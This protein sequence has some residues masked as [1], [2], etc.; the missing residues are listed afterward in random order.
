MNLGGNA[1]SFFRDVFQGFEENYMR[2]VAKQV[3]MAGDELNKMNMRKKDIRIIMEKTEMQDT[4]KNRNVESHVL[5]FRRRKY[6]LRF[7][8]QDSLVCATFAE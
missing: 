4:R 7:F 6:F 1:I 2:T 3:A 5:F 8:L